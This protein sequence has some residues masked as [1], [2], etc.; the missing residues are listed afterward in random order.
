M[1]DYKTCAEEYQTSSH[2]QNAGSS[3]MKVKWSNILPSASFYSYDR[4]PWSHSNGLVMEPL[5][6]RQNLRMVWNL[7]DKM[8]NMFQGDWGIS[9]M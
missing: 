2:V 4:S 9:C 6:S 5:H 1:H 3:V 8:D 7:V